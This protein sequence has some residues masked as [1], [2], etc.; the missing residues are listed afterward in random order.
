MTIIDNGDMVL[1]KYIY[2]IYV[3]LMHFYVGIPI[4]YRYMYYT[5]IL[6]TYYIIR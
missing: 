3:L 6:Y 1:Q 4:E 2:N 5:S